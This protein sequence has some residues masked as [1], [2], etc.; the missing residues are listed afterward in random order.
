MSKNSSIFRSVLKIKCPKCHEGDMFCNKNVYQF[1]GFFDMPDY[2]PKCNQDFQME[3]GF[4][5]GAMFISYALTIAQ[6]VALFVAFVTFNAYSLV[7]FLI[8][9]A[10][11]LI[12]TGPYILKVSRSIRIA[13]S[14]NYDPNAI[15]DY[16][17]QH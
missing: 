11:F 3:A 5:L 13:F 7:P 1:K 16:E 4:Y 6:N 17:A 10:I 14:I 8:T 2:C 15:K 9:A 12:I